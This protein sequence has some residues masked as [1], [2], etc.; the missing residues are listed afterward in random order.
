LSSIKRITA[1]EITMSQAQHD[2]AAFDRFPA[3]VQDL[4]AE[5]GS[6]GIS[7]VVEKFIAAE[8]ADFLWESRFAE[9]N[10]GDFEGLDGDEEGGKLV[11][12]M[13]YFRGEYYVAICI[14]DADRSVRA[15]IKSR[16]FS[17]FESAEIAFLASS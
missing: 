16:E 3:L 12:V 4:T 7:A 6:D 11:A 17:S 5:F 10:L 14:V 15:L 8:Q 13:G 1:M 2:H 9:R